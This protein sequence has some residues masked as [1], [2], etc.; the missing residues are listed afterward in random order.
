M[1]K[2]LPLGT[3]LKLDPQSDK[4]IMVIGRLVKK[5]AADSTMW[6]YCGCTAP[7]GINNVEELIFF[8]HDQIKQLIFIGFQDEDELKYS[9]ALASCKEEQLKRLNH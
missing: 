2:L 9:F 7:H 4:K 5:S 6:D 8:N 3:I 1:K